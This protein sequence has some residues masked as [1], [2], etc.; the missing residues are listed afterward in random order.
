MWLA[1]LLL[2]AFS[3]SSTS[4]L[5]GFGVADLD[6]WS[7]TLSFFLTASEPAKE[8]VVA[9]E[10]KEAGFLAEVALPCSL[11]NSWRKLSGL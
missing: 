9:L 6:D 7:S 5:A 10:A 11:D 3:V 1:G 4:K 2:E 8:T